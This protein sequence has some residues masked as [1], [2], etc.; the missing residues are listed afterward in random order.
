LIDFI[1]MLKQVQ[2]DIFN[3]STITTQ[4]QMGEGDD[5]EK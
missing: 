3:F 5:E 2:H 4:S 1:E